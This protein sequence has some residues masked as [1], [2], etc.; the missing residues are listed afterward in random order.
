M[1]KKNKTNA[2]TKNVKVLLETPAA[3]NLAEML[4]QGETVHKTEVVNLEPGVE[5]GSFLEKVEETFGQSFAGEPIDANSPVEMPTESNPEAANVETQVPESNP[6][7]VKATRRV[8]GEDKLASLADNDLDDDLKVYQSLLA[9]FVG[10]SIT[11]EKIGTSLIVTRKWGC[12]YEAERIAKAIASGDE[13]AMVEIRARA[14]KNLAALFAYVKVF[15]H[16]EHPTRHATWVA[17]AK[18]ITRLSLVAKSKAAWNDVVRG[19][20]LEAFGTKCMAK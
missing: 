4:E 16:S 7:P 12:Q 11:K 20:Y 14:T 10:G 5:P 1:A 15:E 8:E 9:T 18:R 19:F 13:A 6:E 17:A 3:D 2:E